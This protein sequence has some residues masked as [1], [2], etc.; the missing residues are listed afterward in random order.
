MSDSQSIMTPRAGPPSFGSIAV[1]G[2]RPASFGELTTAGA[3]Y[4][5][6]EA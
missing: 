3:E 1:P 2:D 5:E 4:E 6:E